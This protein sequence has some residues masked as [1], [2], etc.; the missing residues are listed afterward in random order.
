M[1]LHSSYGRHNYK[2]G[3]GVETGGKSKSF[4]LTCVLYIPLTLLSGSFCNMRLIVFL[5]SYKVNLL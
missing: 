4:L 2:D 1:S 5:V 3:K